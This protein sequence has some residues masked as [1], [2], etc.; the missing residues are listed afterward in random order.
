MEN[1]SLIGIRVYSKPIQ[2][3]LN[4][5]NDLVELQKGEVTFDDIS[6]G[7]ISFSVEM[8]GFFWE[9]CFSVT[10]ID[11]DLSKITLEI[12]GN[13]TNKADRL[14]R[15]FALLESMFM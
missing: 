7:K 15:Q 14:N 10:E 5:I 12:E 11:N 9:Y 3:M 1:Y 13:I 6:H 2:A 8:Y 4:A